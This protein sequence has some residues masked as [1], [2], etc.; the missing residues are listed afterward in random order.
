[1]IPKQLT[2]Q[3]FLSYQ[4]V[5]LNFDGLHVACVCGPNGA[6]KSSLLEAIAWCVW[7]QSRV[8]AEDDIIRQGAKEVQV[9]FCFEHNAQ[10][11]RIIRTR[12]RNQNSALEFQIQQS[13]AG[14]D[15][16][17]GIDGSPFKTITQKGTRATQRYILSQLKIDYETFVNAAYLR[18]GRAD[19]FMLKRPGDRKQV[20]ADLL[21]LDHYDRLAEQAKEKAR[22]YQ[23]Q[24][25]PLEAL[26][27]QLT[28]Q[29]ETQ[30]Q[31][32]A[33]HEKLK[34]DLEKQQATYQ[35]QQAKLEA[36][37]LRKQQKT[38]C[39]QQLA[40]AEQQLQHQRATLH[41]SQVSLH[42]AQQALQECLSTLAQTDEVE[43]QQQRL[44]SLKRAEEEQ[45][46]QFQT[47]QEAQSQKF[48]YQQ[49]L[50]DQQQQQQS[51][52]N[53]HK[54]QL[55]DLHSQEQE[56]LKTLERKTEITQKQED[57]RLAKKQLR[58]L[59]KM[60]SRY[61]PLQQRQQQLQSKIEQAHTRLVTRIEELDNRHAQMEIQHTQAPQLRQAAVEVTHRIEYL[62]QRR[63]YREAVRQ[64][65]IERRSFMERLQANQ[66]NYEIQLAQF[67]QTLKQLADP[68]A[69]CCPLC[70]QTLEGKTWQELRDRTHQERDDIQNQIWVVREQLAV[71]ESEI[72]TLRREYREL[73]EEL[74]K[75]APV[76]EE[77]G[78]LKAKLASTNTL[79][80]RIQE[81]GSER[82]QLERCLQENDYAENLHEELQQVERQL[83]AIAYDDR[84]HAL[85]RAQIER[86]RWS[87]I[88]YAEIRQAEHRLNKIRTQKPKVERS[89]QD[90]L[91]ALETIKTSE[92]YKALQQ[93]EDCLL[94]LN[95]SLAQHNQLRAQLRQA[96]LWD[97]RYQ[98]LQQARSQEKGLTQQL[99]NILKICEQQETTQTEIEKNVSHLKQTFAEYPNLQAEI[100]ATESS[101]ANYQAQRDRQLSQLGRLQQQLSQLENLK[102]QR[103][104]HQQRLSDLAH[105]YQVYKSLSTA[106]GRNGIQSLMV[107]NLLPQLEAETNQ[108]LGKLSDHQLHV[109]FVTQKSGRNNR[110]IDT[111]DILIADARGT[112]PYETYS[113]GE[114]FRVN[115]AIR[116]AIARLL[117][118]RSGMSLK[119]LIV[120]E[121]FGT[122]DREGCDRLIAA[123]EAIAPDFACILTITHMPHFREAFQTRID[124]TKDQDGSHILISG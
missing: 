89:L 14:S 48:H 124:V 81:M 24:V 21:K 94:T 51:Q 83:A 30:G 10:T 71:C 82:S 23:A 91:A 95:Y 38:H 20:L 18:Q 103:E 28:A 87:E 31:I 62:E 45:A 67:D 110:K 33:D 44:S 5:T 78:Q 84:D 104:K 85:V 116:L 114:A 121:G 2:L 107:E 119:M 117:A 96:S 27:S 86:L 7:G 42:Q 39:S 59:D 34:S 70:E 60:Q 49:V 100:A 106:F 16:T 122:Q 113:G 97:K 56:L 52:L 102:T 9:S 64:K 12:R 32:Q 63:T 43:Q 35:Q 47:Y 88:K 74:A 123:I 108:I 46:K 101:I 66:V 99:S 4:E 13:P 22:G 93:I 79:Q 69:A 37:N 68:D 29:I 98:T 73:E 19:E 8:S 105:K 72:Q 55:A 11:Y 36:L 57:Y 40:L 80:N 92:S 77:R 115:F 53:Q 54:A 61:V 6:G 109:Q 65:G 41:V 76:L 112:R 90:T 26:F 58:Q 120:D 25:Q 118:L 75:Y 111:L 1:M 15:S 17:Q 50:G 3:N